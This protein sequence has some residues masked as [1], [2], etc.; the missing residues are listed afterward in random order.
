MKEQSWPMGADF[1]YLK[2]CLND[3][4]QSYVTRVKK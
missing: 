3:K 4:D 1:S 2:F